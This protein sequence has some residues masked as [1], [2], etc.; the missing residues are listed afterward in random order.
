MPWITRRLRSLPVP[1]SLEE[2]VD[3][4]LDRAL[5]IQRRAVIGYVDHHRTRKPHATPAE[6]IDLLERRYKAAVV[7]VGAA[8]GG[9]AAF[10]G[11]GTATSVATGILEISAFVE[12]TALFTLAVAEVHGLQV[13]DQETRRALVLTVLLG[14]GGIAAVESATQSEVSHWTHALRRGVPQETIGKVNHVL[15]RHVLTRFGTEQGALLLGRALPLGIGAG[16]G[17]VGN[18]V[19]ARSVI[20]T[21]RRTFGPPPAKMPPRIID[22]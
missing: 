12:A 21:A 18:L 4:A 7:S 19:L 11:V 3:D 17:A 22:A 16:I 6:V 14:Q 10:P 5:A 9:A 13:S 1:S 20:R 15:A 2:G 8:S